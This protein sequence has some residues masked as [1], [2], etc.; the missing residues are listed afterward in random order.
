[1][2]WGPP[3]FLFNGYLPS[4]PGAEQ[5]GRDDDHSPSSS[6]KVNKAWSHTSAPSICIHGLDKDIFTW[7]HSSQ[8]NN[9]DALHG[10]ETFK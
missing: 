2:L 8:D 1:M 4:I 10:K 3:S 7:R 5:P 6:A 9:L